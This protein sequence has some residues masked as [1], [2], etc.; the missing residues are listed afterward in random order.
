MAGHGGLQVTPAM[1][2]EKGPA[3]SFKLTLPTTGLYKT[4]AQF[5]HH[6][7]RVLTVPFTFHVDEIWSEPSSPTTI[8]QAGPGGIQQATVIIDGEYSPAS[9]A[10]KAGRPVRL[11]FIRKE[12]AG[13]GDE[14]CTE[15]K[16][17]ECRH[18]HAEE[19]RHDP[20]HLR[21]ENVPGAGHGPVTSL[22]I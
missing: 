2:T 9:I 4:W 1:A 22:R 15:G 8:A 3:F 5:L 19:G 7:N 18:V 12:E 14:L 6:R 13:C 11:T 10:V 17:E 21:N 20:L 16:S